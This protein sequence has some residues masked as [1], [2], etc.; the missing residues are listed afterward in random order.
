M[1]YERLKTYNIYTRRYFYPLCSE[2]NCY[3]ALP[4]AELGK[5][6]VARKA[7]N[8]V[9]ALP[10]FGSLGDEGAHRVSDAIAYL[11]EG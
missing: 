3:R 4:S 6:P 5:L 9:L 10:F 1:M 7:A 11:L 8:E 2:A